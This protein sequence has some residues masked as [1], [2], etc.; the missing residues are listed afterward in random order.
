MHRAGLRSDGRAT[1][2][3]AAALTSSTITSGVMR[4]A[5]PSTHW[6]A[7]EEVEPSCDARQR[8]AR[9]ARTSGRD[10]VWDPAAPRPRGTRAARR[11]PPP[12]AVEPQPAR[13]RGD[14]RAARGV[15]TAE[16]PPRRRGSAP[17]PPAARTGARAATRP[18]ARPQTT[19][20]P[21]RR[22]SSA[23]RHSHHVQELE[24]REGRVVAVLLRVPDRERRDREQR[25]GEDREIAPAGDAAGEQD[26]RQHL[27]RAEEGGRH[28]RRGLE[29]EG[30]PQRE[31]D[32][33]EVQWR[34][35]RTAAGCGGR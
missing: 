34:L 1:K 23:R 6:H 20:S 4:P 14:R 24:R 35:E 15:S 27:E 7:P 29:P 22:R 12:S 30:Q 33:D 10:D 9:S 5:L 18:T 31:P 11:R 28:A 21:G 25:A 13:R 19:K 3:A 16:P 32:R 17:A 2:G 26:Q 8:A